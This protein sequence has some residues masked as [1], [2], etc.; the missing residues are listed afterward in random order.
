MAQASN[1]LILSGGLG[2]E[3]V[4]GAKMDIPAGN[5]MTNGRVDGTQS[6]YVV[7]NEPGYLKGAKD[8]SANSS[9]IVD[10]PN[11]IELGF[12]ARSAQG[13]DKVGISIMEH[14]Y[15][16]GTGETY[17]SSNP[18]ITT[19]FPS[20]DAGVSSFFVSKGV[21]AVYSEKNYKGVQLEVDGKTEFGPGFRAPCM[22]ANDVVK[23]VKLL[24]EN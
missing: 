20:G 7:Y 9:K 6:F 15:Y 13:W 21:W 8:W 23:S 19:S 12:T 3:Q 11:E 14:I 16:C 18:D 22:R 10:G 4:F 1:A 5:D 24:R 17:R 2:T